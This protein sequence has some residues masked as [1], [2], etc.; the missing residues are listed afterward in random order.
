METILCYTEEVQT[1]HTGWYASHR[2]F[3]ECHSLCSKLPAIWN[4]ERSCEEPSLRKLCGSPGS[5][6]YVIAECS[7]GL[8]NLIKCQ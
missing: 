8:V 5:L 6:A 2:G 3:C 4:S 7:N 1:V